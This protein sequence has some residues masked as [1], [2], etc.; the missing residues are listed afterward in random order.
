[1][2]PQLDTVNRSILCRE[3]DFA[4]ELR[5]VRVGLRHPTRGTQ[6]YGR[7]LTRMCSR[8]WHAPCIQRLSPP[9][10]HRR[11]WG[12]RSRRT[13]TVLDRPQRFRQR[14]TTCSGP[15]LSVSVVRRTGGVVR[16]TSTASSRQRR[17][18]FLFP[19]HRVP[20]AP[21]GLNV[22]DQRGCAG[23]IIRPEL[24]PLGICCSLEV[25]FAIED[26]EIVLSPMRKH[27]RVD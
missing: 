4:V 10:G 6:H 8:V 21:P 2:A 1:M 14:K 20:V 18:M 17:S 11:L 27:A 7:G 19:A 16:R 15:P 22:V 23:A 24:D 26:G 25:Q 9:R 3:V 13:A 12:H 5:Q